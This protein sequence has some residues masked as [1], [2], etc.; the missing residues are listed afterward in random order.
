MTLSDIYSKQQYKVLKSRYLV[1]RLI[2]LRT[3]YLRMQALTIWI[4]LQRLGVANRTALLDL[5]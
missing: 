3:L 4:L 1:V 5:I 2:K